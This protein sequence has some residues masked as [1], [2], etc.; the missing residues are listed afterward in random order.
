MYKTIGDQILFIYKTETVVDRLKMYSAYPVR[1]MVESEKNPVN[2]EQ[3]LL[4]DDE[5]VLIY[6]ECDRAISRIFQIA[7][8]LSKGIIDG[9]I[10]NR[11]IQISVS[12][13]TAPG[14]T[15]PEVDGPPLPQVTNIT[16]YGFRLANK[17]AYN[18]NLLPMIDTLIE[19]LF[20][21]MVM[22]KWFVITRQELAKDEQQHSAQLAIEF[23]NSLTELYKPLIQYFNIIPEFTQEVIT[24]D[25]ET[26][27]I[28][29][30]VTGEGGYVPPT[31]EVVS[32]VLYF[33]SSASFPLVGT[34]DIIYVD[35]TSK[36]M[37]SWNGTAYEL[38]SATVGTFEQTFFDVDYII[39]E[40]NLGKYMPTVQMID[41][42]GD[43]WD[44]DTEPVSVN[45]TICQWIGNKTG[46]L[47]FS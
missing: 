41:S 20:I 15:L 8:K 11:S 31:T 35:R 13:E 26:E 14:G 3:L 18:D 6:A 24:Y 21:S 33:A 7:Y 44:I 17:L 23:N 4:T 19:D 40:H 1:P 36:L 12:E 16:G 43:E 47:Y 22:Y 46:T 39:V 38:Y 34:P 32:E 27:E 5:L 28:T 2:R 9:L 42:E 37:Y 45:I 30:T 10:K 29:D 25:P